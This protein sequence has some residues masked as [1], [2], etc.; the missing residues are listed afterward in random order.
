MA[1]VPSANTS[2]QA[3]AG[4]VATGLDLICVMSPCALN[5]DC[6]P[7]IFGKAA[8]LYA[9]HG[10]CEGVDFTELHVQATRKAVMFCG[11]P[12]AT[13]GVVGR[14]NMSGNTGSSV[15]DVTA[16]VSGVL[17]EHAGVVVVLKGGVV[18]TDQIM[19]GVSFDFGTT[20][21]R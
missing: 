20:F 13:P 9:F 7:R 8:D 1:D 3:T 16:G 10:Y 14:K 18:G 5:A 2:V 21:K 6:K 19:L 11:L 12:I 15:V 4:G 17:G